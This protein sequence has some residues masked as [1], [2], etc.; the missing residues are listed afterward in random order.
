VEEEWLSASW[1]P[2]RISTRSA[3]KDLDAVRNVLRTLFVRVNL[4]EVDGELLL[5]PDPRVGVIAPWPDMEIARYYR[6]HGHLPKRPDAIVRQPL[7]LGEISEP[8]GLAM[9]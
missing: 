8:F 6:R 3:A 9:R 2:P 1:T 7:L 4:I 5:D